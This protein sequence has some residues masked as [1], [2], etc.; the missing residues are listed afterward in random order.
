MEQRHITILAMNAERTCS[1]K[2]MVLKIPK[3]RLPNE[4]CKYMYID[5]FQGFAKKKIYIFKTISFKWPINNLQLW[6]I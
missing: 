3:R 2:A 1:S 4:I 5:S 6:Y